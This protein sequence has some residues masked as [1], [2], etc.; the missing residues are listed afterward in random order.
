MAKP[1]KINVVSGIISPLFLIKHYTLFFLVFK[2][3]TVLN[4]DKLNENV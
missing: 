1:I 3:H 4:S 2:Y